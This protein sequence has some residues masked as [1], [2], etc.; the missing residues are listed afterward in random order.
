MLLAMIN[1]VE[2]NRML[3]GELYNPYKV[4]DNTFETVHMAQKKF[5]ETSF[6]SSSMWVL[7]LI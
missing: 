7:V 6:H 1:K 2:W 4:G 5:N 3:A